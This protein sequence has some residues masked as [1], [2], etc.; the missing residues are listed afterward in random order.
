MQRN[1]TMFKRIL[2]QKPSISALHNQW[3][4]KS[5]KSAG[6]LT[7]NLL[8]PLSRNNLYAINQQE[9]AQERQQQDKQV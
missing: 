4:L 5:G 7:P 1:F 8:L 6:R 2:A 9:Q 3:L